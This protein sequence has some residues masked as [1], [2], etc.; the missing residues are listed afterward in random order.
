MHLP[1]APD[2]K[3]RPG[4][5]PWGTDCDDPTRRM[6]RSIETFEHHLNETAPP[7]LHDC[8]ATK[9]HWAHACAPGTM[10][11]ATDWLAAATEKV[12]RA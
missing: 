6:R 2:P 7:R 9:P 3:P 1:T 4:D 11:E 10:A 5:K 8:A 12:L